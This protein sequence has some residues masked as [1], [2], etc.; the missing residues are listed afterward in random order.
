MAANNG[1]ASVARLL[2]KHKNYVI[3]VLDV[4][5]VLPNL[6][7]KGIFSVEEESNVLQEKIQTRRTEVFLDILLKKGTGAFREFGLTLE[8][9]DPHLMRYLLAD[10]N[11]ELMF[12]IADDLNEYNL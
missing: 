3:R 7:H 10:N 11:G 9:V 8:L 5:K 6:V 2:E 1:V 4:T 12:S